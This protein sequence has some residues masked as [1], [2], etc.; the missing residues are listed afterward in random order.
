M[1]GNPS[2]SGARRHC[3]LMRGYLD[4]ETLGDRLATL[5]AVV[6]DAA[7]DVEFGHVSG[8]AAGRDV[9]ADSAVAVDG[10]RGPVPAEAG[11]IDQVPF[12]KS[13]RPEDVKNPRSRAGWLRRKPCGC[14]TRALKF[15]KPDRKSV[16]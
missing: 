13:A 10:P 11:D 5:C 8:R 3:E 16:V 6:G 12:I 4:F 2:N 15:S 1:Q 7:Q 9:V 14:R